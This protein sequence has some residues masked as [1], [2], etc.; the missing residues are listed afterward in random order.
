MHERKR[1]DAR[2]SW[3]ALL[4]DT[5][6]AADPQFI[7]RKDEAS[8]PLL[9]RWWLWCK[10]ADIEFVSLSDLVEPPPPEKPKPEPPKGK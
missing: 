9:E 2:R 3:C 10:P 6:I 5:K 8:R 1:D 7:F 4:K